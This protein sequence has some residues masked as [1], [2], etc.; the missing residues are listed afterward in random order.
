MRTL[1]HLLARQAVEH[2]LEVHNYFTPA[3][4]AEVMI[5]ERIA[6][7]MIQ[8]DAKSIG[9][10]FLLFGPDQI[11]VV[12]LAELAAIMQVRPLGIS[13]ENG[14]TAVCFPDWQFEPEGDA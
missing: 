6:G 13:R 3:Y 7:C 5:P 14:L 12:V 2:G 10:F 11:D 1:P 9:A 8:G 4:Y